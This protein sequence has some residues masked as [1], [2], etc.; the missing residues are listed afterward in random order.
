MVGNLAILAIDS[1]FSEQG[2]MDWIMVDN[3]LRRVPTSLTFKGFGKLGS[4]G[5]EGQPLKD[6]EGA[7]N[8]KVKY[9]ENTCPIVIDGSVC[10]L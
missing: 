6:W 9:E 10:F 3:N 8:V 7:R 5:K 4:Q 2:D 1:A